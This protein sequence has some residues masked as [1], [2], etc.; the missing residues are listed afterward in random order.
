MCGKYSPL[1]DE[2]TSI[3]S[4]NLHN[5]I[6]PLLLHIYYVATKHK[7]GISPKFHPIFPHCRAA[8]LPSPIYFVILK[9]GSFFK[10]SGAI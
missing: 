4:K 8:I 1:E 2:I 10:Y 6:F 9:N 5:C 7:L 3:Y